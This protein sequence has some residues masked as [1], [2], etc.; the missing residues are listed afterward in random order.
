M[1]SYAEFCLS[2]QTVWS[3]RMWRTLPVRVA[4]KKKAKGMNKI[5]I[6]LRK[7]TKLFESGK[8]REKTTQEF[9]PAYWLISVYDEQRRLLKS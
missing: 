5:K 2:F 9:Y 3:A 4:T 6:C 8:L 1:I 7:I